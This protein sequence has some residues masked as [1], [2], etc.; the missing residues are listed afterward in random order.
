MET[1]MKR[2]TLAAA[3][4]VILS[5]PALAA[6][7]APTDQIV[8]DNGVETACTGVGSAKDD[9]QFQNWP[10]QIEFS[11]TGAQYLS[12]VHIVL[13]RN[14]QVVRD[15]VCNAPWFLVRGTGS[16]KVTGSFEGMKDKSATFSG[17]GAHKRLVL[18]FSKAPNS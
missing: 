9:P 18:Q 17:E 5:T 13:A 1:I 6:D 4:V 15:T 12:G 14:G 11:N 8:S 16:Y 7:G 2:I 10:A 3:A